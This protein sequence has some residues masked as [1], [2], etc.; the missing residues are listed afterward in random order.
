MKLCII[1]CMLIALV[2]CDVLSEKHQTTVINVIEQGGILW[3]DKDGDG[4]FETMLTRGELEILADD[5]K[6]NF[7]G[8][9]HGG[10]KP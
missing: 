6:V 9:V 1:L 8:E 7:I 3:A 5:A 2:G 4:V 10:T